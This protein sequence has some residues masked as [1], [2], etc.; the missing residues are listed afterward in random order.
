MGRSTNIPAQPVDQTYASYSDLRLEIPKLTVSAS[1]VGVP[2]SIEGWDV[3][4]LGDDA[5]WLNG[6]AF[7]TGPGNSVITGHVW[8]AY[9]Q[10][11]IFYDLK[12]LVYGDVIKVHAF[13]QVC[14]TEARESKR[15]TPK[16]IS[17]AVQH[18]EKAWL[19]RVTCEE[20]R[21]LFKTYN[22][23]RIVRAVLVDIQ[24]EK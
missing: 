23:R 6:T 9:N 16:N 11:G 3:T 22:Y 19:T 15:I 24:A 18:E 12:K 7:P 13:G 21:V 10:P 4:W 14:T 5:G 2:L 20:Y 17:A 8:D 1:I